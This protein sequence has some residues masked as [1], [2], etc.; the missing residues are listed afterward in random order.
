MGDPITLP[1]INA[2]GLNRLQDAFPNAC[3]EGTKGGNQRAR[4][5]RQW[6]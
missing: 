1:D 3:R 4:T 2:M 6:L 5:A